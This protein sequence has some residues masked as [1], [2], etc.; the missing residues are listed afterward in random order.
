[1]SSVLKPHMDYPE[2]WD[3]KDGPNPELLAKYLSWL[4]QD[5]ARMESATADM[6]WLPVGFNTLLVARR[7]NEEKQTTDETLQLNFYS[8]D[9]PGNEGPHGH[10]KPAVTHWY[11]HPNARQVIT[12]HLPLPE[13]ARQIEGLPIKERLVAANCIVD[14]R[15]G[16]RPI[17]NPI[18]LGSR[19]ILEQSETRVAPL[20]SQWFGSIEVHNVSFEGPEV[21]ISV[22]HKGAEESPE[23]SSSRGL[24][25]YKGLTPEQSDQV[26]E[27]RQKLLTNKPSSKDNL[28]PRLGPVTMLYPSDEAEVLGMEL[29]MPSPNRSIA[30]DLILGGLKTAKHL[31]KNR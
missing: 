31:V 25:D 19:F 6:Q 20:G 26:V 12:R 2:I 18:I 30:E 22:H 3:L 28:K 10:S 11:A 15:D 4:T 14:L 21:A 24:T 29:I 5:G 16:R 7:W 27:V 23:L 9:M 1:M 8:E 13:R 17:Y